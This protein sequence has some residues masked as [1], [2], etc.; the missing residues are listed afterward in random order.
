VKRLCYRGMNSASLREAVG[1]RLSRYLRADAFAFLALEPATGLPVHAVHDWPSDMCNAAQDRALLVSP[2]ADFGRR[3]RMQRRVHVVEQL[4]PAPSRGTDVYLAE[5]LRPFGFAHEVQMSCAA[6]GRIWGN[7]HLTRRDGRSAFSAS[8]IALLEA[9]VPHVTAGLRSAA[10]R[11][12]LAA[13]P[14]PA[15]GMVLLGPGGG[16]ELAN[17]VA[18]RLLREDASGSRLRRWVAIQTVASLLKRVVDGDEDVV[19]ALDLVDNERGEVYR[20]RGERLRQA[21][22][23]VRDL[24]LIEPGR[25]SDGAQ[26]LSSLGLTGREQEV[27]LSVL[28]GLSTKEMAAALNL[29]PHTVQTHVRHVLEKLGVDSRRALASLLSGHRS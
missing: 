1:E 28:R 8:A 15:V 6:A 27:A 17:A 23:R 7:L 21:D 29:S 18:L 26:L 24:V 10:G 22:G 11:D 16:I 19:P 3:P 14:G 12:T 20:L 2:A 25:L 4:A 13:S 5:V 9:L